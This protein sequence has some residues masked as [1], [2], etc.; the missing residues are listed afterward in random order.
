M[1]YNNCIKTIRLNA[2]AK[3]Y[4]RKIIKIREIADIVLREH[5]FAVKMFFS[6]VFRPLLIHFECVENAFRIGL[7]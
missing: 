2:C 5:D 3:F 4:I 7:V 1:F 6:I